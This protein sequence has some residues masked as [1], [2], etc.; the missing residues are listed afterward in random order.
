ML[1]VLAV[2]V[3]GVVVH[4]L[5]RF[6]DHS[7]N[8][9]VAEDLDIDPQDLGQLFFRTYWPEIIIGARDLRETMNQLMPQINPAISG[10]QL[11]DYWF[12]NDARL[13]RAVA[14]ELL[15]W[16]QRTGGVLVAATNQE[17]H[18]MAYL[19]EK[20]GL[21]EIFDD[22][23]F[24]GEV[25]ATKSDLAFFARALTRLGT[26]TP[27]SVMFIDD[28][29]G[30]VATATSAGWSAYLF[31]GIDGLRLLLAQYPAAARDLTAGS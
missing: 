28:D 26:D 14:D 11:V 4:P 19:I 1:P 27:E 18:R 10:D 20:V 22:V 17:R 31:T 13:D 6:G 9:F 21:G 30:N 25:G 7:W 23:I 15:A 12:A 24:S 16:K 3:D 29:P 8:H 5:E 2:D